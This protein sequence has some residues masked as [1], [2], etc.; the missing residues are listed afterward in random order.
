[1]QRFKNTDNGL[2]QKI[3]GK[4]QKVRDEYKQNDRLHQLCT[5]HMQIFPSAQ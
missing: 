3:K 1:M 5:K 2:M 4:K